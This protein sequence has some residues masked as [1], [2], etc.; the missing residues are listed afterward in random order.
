MMAK[1]C[2]FK[3]RYLFIYTTY[4]NKKK[5]LHCPPKISY[6]CVQH[7]SQNTEQQFQQTALSD[8]T[9]LTEMRYVF[10]EVQAKVSCTIQ[11]DFVLHGAK[12]QLRNGMHT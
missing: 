6:L 10:C 1:Y 7:D 2:P 12:I 9:S 11:M 5:T 8:L 4:C 3:A